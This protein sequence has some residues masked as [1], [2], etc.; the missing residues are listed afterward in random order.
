MIVTGNRANSCGK[1]SGGCGNIR[2]NRCKK[3]AIGGAIKMGVVIVKAEKLNLP[4]RKKKL[5]NA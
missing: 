2:N 4:E 3:V 5:T 1:K